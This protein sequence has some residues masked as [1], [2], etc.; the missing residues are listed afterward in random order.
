M[1]TTYQG[2]CFIGRQEA[3]V[4]VP[5]GDGNHNSWG[6]GRNVVG[7]ALNTPPLTVEQAWV[8]LGEDI[9]RRE[10]DI[11]RWLTVPV[12]PHQHDCLVST[13]FQAGSQ[14][15]T[16]IDHLNRGGLDSAMQALCSIVRDSSHRTFRLGLAKRRLAEATLF[17]EGDYGD[18]STFKLWDA[19]PRTTAFRWHAFPPPETHNAPQVN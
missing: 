17:T 19:N 14:V 13:Y 9:E 2:R 6:F 8:M 12:Q 4:L 1:L 10:A 3:C 16:V 18:I 11:V 5:Y 15:R 7:L